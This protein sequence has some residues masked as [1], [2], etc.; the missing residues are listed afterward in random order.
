MLKS[1]SIINYRNLEELT[2][3]SVSQIN[4]ITGKNNTGKSSLLEAIALLACGGDL[5][6]IISLLDKHGYLNYKSPTLKKSEMAIQSLSTLFSGRKPQFFG[7]GIRIYDNNNCVN[8]GFFYHKDFLP[9]DDMEVRRPLLEKEIEENNRYKIGLEIKM[10]NLHHTIYQEDIQNIFSKE[11]YYYNTDKFQFIESGDSNRIINGNLFDKIVL[12]TPEDIVVEALQIIEP[13][14]KRIGFRNEEPERQAVIKLSTI[15][16]VIPISDLGDGIHRILTIIL[17][18]VNCQNGFLL[19]DE[20]ENGLH[21]SVQE[22]LW[23]IIF[24]L[25]KDLNIQVFATTHS[26]DCISNFSKV[27]NEEN[28]GVTGQLIRLDNKNGKIKATKFLPKELIIA[29]KRDIEIR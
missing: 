28:D 7:N 24:K 14:I 12:K 21:Y 15:D 2:I 8:I 27:L 20:F 16:E 18:A 4:L 5:D 26:N 17:A 29:T 11:G 19:I 22:K 10:H 13:E 25:A 23:K 9:F 3:D 1:L 6:Y